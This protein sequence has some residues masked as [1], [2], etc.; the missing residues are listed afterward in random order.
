ME[1]ELSSRITTIG[2]LPTVIDT[3]ANREDM[4]NADHNSWTKVWLQQY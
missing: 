1:K 4:P 2:V 3:P